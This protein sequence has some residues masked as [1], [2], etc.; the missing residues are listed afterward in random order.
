MATYQ[1]KNGVRRLVSLAPHDVARQLRERLTN[2][3]D[4]CGKLGLKVARGSN[5]QKATICCPWHEDRTPSCSVRVAKDGTIAVRCHG[6]GKTAD[7]LGLIAKVHDSETNFRETLR[8]AAEL[9]NA[10]SLAPT[11]HVAERQADE[12]VCSNTD[13]ERAWSFTIEACGH[14]RTAAPHV[15]EYLLGRG[16]Y[17]DAEAVGCVG[18]PRDTRPLVK[19]LLSTFSRSVLEGAGVLRPGHDAIDWSDHSLVIPWRDPYGRINCVQR[20]CLDSRTPK[21]VLPPKRS[22]RYPFG[23]EYA[24]AAL[25]YEGPTAEIVFVEGA[26]DALARRRV[27]RERDERAVILGVFS[28]SAPTAGLPLDLI[29]GRVVNLALDVDAA[30]EK[31]CAQ[32]Y[33]SLKGVAL[34]FVREKVTGAKDWGQALAGGSDEERG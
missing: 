16:I 31:A 32:I 9:A 17:A 23:I 6:C 27:A 33:H 14:M 2:V 4:L 10:P 29:R 28:A 7:A 22:P 15:A 12:P 3:S 34:R 26:L 19:A 11:E 20:R 24:K 5:A 25:E 13:F 30:G 1:T 21:Y 18:L 8:I